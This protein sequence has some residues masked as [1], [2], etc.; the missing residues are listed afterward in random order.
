LDYEFEEWKQREFAERFGTA[1]AIW[2]FQVDSYWTRSSY[3][4][5]F[6]T[7]ALT[8]LWQVFRAGYNVTS[9]F[10]CLL[11]MVLT[12][13]WMYNNRRVHKY[14]DYW[15]KRGASIEEEFLVKAER[16]FIAGYEVLRNDEPLMRYSHLVQLIPLL[17]IASWA[18][19]FG[20]SAW[21]LIHQNPKPWCL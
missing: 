18:W 3:F 9:L 11:G 4:A 21:T 15:W 19:L 2:K 1:I 16:R 13:I 20:L 5:L 14:V 6:E 7:A 8:A 17:F 12:F 10:L